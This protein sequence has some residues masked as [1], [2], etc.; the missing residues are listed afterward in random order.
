[1]KTQ[2][3]LELQPFQAAL[4]DYFAALDGVQLAVLYGSHARA[5]ENS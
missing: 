4:L 3:P 1:M 5:E 2:L